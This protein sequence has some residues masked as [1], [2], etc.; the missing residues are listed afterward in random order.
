MGIGI[1]DWHC[2]N[3]SEVTF[4]PTCPDDCRHCGG[5]F[6]TADI[7]KLPKNKKQNKTMATILNSVMFS[8][9]HNERFLGVEWHYVGDHKITSGAILS[10]AWRVEIKG[11]KVVFHTQRNPNKSNSIYFMKEILKG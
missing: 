6:L 3:C 7:S 5:K 9:V 1:I 10:N 11:E 4:A 8:F 2:L